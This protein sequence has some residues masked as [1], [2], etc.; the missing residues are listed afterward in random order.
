MAILLKEPHEDALSTVMILALRCH[1]SAAT[2]VETGIVTHGRLGDDGTHRL[3]MLLLDLNVEVLPL[4]A[5]HA[6]HA[7]DAFRRYGKGRHPAR[8]NL[9]DCF[10]YALAKALDEP[11]LFVGDDFSQTDITAVAY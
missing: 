3:D 11:L 8:L 2:L 6:F 10:S 4:T 7:R 5:L 1:L 9:G